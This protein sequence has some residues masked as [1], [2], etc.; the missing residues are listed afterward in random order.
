MHVGGTKLTSNT[1]LMLNEEKLARS[2]SLSATPTCIIISPGQFCVTVSQWAAAQLAQV[3][4]TKQT[5]FRLCYG[6][7]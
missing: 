3:A 4:R 6:W 5:C 2:G 1:K 7:S